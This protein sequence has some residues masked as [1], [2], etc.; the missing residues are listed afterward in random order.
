[1]KSED[2]FLTS[3]LKAAKESVVYWENRVRELEATS[4]SNPCDEIAVKVS[5]EHLKDA[6]EAVEKY[7]TLIKLGD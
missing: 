3:L 4:S 2:P 5:K 7:E 1:M 6:K